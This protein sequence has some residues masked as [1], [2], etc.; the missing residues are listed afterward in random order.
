MRSQE[1]KK[2]EKERRNR[3]ELSTGIDNYFSFKKYFPCLSFPHSAGFFCKTNEYEVGEFR[4]RWGSRRIRMEKRGRA[5]RKICFFHFL[6]PSISVVQPRSFSPPPPRCGGPSSSSPPYAQNPK[7]IYV[8]LVFS[9][10]PP[11]RTKKSACGGP[12]KLDGR[13]RPNGCP[14]AQISHRDISA[15]FLF[16]LTRNSPTFL[17]IRAFPLY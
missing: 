8:T 4:T 5:S 9:P 16:P 6:L 17:C 1:E 15:L 14:I 12:D 7:T 11:L 10:P 13:R 2:R 3:T